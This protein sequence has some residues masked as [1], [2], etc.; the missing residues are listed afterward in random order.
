M[1]E[2]RE[3]L[4]RTSK[5]GGEIDLRDDLGSQYR[6]R[7]ALIRKRGFEARPLDGP[8]DR[9]VS[10]R[11][12]EIT[13]IANETKPKLSQLVESPGTPT[14]KQWNTE[15]VKPIDK[16]GRFRLVDPTTGAIKGQK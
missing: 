6:D 15:M 9:R 10:R 14:T 16:S 1:A 12:Q 5:V 13:R 3:G 11:R 4:S 7:D 8:A 2:N